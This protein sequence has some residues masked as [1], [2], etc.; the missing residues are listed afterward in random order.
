MS[1]HTTSKPKQY[2]GH[3]TFYKILNELKLL[4]DKKNKQYASDTIPLGN[5]Y[6]GSK[7]I[8]K[9][10]N[11]NINNKPLSFALSLM[12]KQVDA[13]YDIVGDNKTG[14]EEELEDKLKDIAV[15]SILCIILIKEQK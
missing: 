13:V 3:P 10:I 15:Y 2:S 5:F 1:T 7:L 9:L 14:T 4:H 8:S 6:R 12:A 11:P